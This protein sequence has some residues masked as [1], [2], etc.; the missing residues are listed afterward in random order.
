MQLHRKLLSLGIL[1]GLLGA[2]WKALGA[3]LSTKL[4]PKSVLEALLGGSEGNLGPKSQQD[5]KSGQHVH[6]S[7]AHTGSIWRAKSIK[8]G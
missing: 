5:R 8:I 7:Y 6:K 1:L 4:A 3:I 2:S